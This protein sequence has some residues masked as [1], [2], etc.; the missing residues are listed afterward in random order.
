MVIRLQ[1]DRLRLAA[2][3][4]HELAITGVA[5]ISEQ[6]AVAGIEQR[7]QRQLQGP[8]GSG[9]HHHLA[10]ADPGGETI[11]VILGDSFAQGGQ[12][13]RRRIAGMAVRYRILNGRKHWLGSIKIRLAHLQ[14]DHIMALSRQGLG[15]L[16]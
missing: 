11:L 7:R 6:H 4:T 1:R 10:R 3:Q 14:V 15:T 16:Q 13:R 5:G 12:A 8:G 9:R 2:D